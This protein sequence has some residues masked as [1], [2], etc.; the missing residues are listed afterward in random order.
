LQEETIESAIGM[1]PG[2]YSDD[3][4]EHFRDVLWETTYADLNP[5]KTLPAKR[6]EPP[7][8]D[9]TLAGQIKKLRDECRLTTEELAENISL[10]T[11]SVQRHL[12]GTTQP[13]TRHLRAYER[14]FSKLLERKVVMNRLS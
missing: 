8:P 12:A 5:P 7:K 9:S 6:A 13:Y 10:D 14:L 4:L 11:R 1:I 2:G 3:L